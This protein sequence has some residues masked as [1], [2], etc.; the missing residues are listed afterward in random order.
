MPLTPSPVFFLS[1]ICPSF[2][3]LLFFFNVH[4]LILLILYRK[5]KLET[6]WPSR[7]PKANP[8]YLRLRRMGWV[9]ESS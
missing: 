3:S 5:L 4:L 8:H 2:H 1:L 7:S 9:L 6:Q